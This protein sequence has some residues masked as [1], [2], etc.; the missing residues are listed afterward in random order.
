MNSL[1]N[2]YDIL[3][4]DETFWLP[5]FS[6]NF[7][8]EIKITD[9]EAEFDIY[10]KWLTEYLTNNSV[11][12]TSY[13]L[14]ILERLKRNN[15]INN[16]YIL[17]G[18]GVSQYDICSEFGIENYPIDFLDNPDPSRLSPYYLEDFQRSY[19]LP[20]FSGLS[21][22]DNLQVSLVFAYISMKQLNLYKEFKE[23][24][25]IDIGWRAILKEGLQSVNNHKDKVEFTKNF[26]DEVSELSTK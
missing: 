7:T 10:C 4:E 16:I 17:A 13:Q 25:W 11:S 26:I 15:E 19:Y 8:P 9:P 22:F 5:D 3:A 24:K 6:N 2:I 20:K 1:K 12:I 23:L 14:S 21:K 18:V